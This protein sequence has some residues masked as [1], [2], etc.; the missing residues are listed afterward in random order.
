MECDHSFSFAEQV[1]LLIQMLKA[2]AE[3]HL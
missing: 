3:K 1:E 2:Y